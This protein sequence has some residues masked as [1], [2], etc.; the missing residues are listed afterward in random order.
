[1]T[2]VGKKK[3][4]GQVV[5]IEIFCWPGASCCWEWCGG[6]YWGAAGRR[7]HFIWPVPGPSSWEWQQCRG[8]GSPVVSTW[9]LSHD[10]FWHTFIL[11]FSN[12]HDNDWNIL[13]FISNVIL[14]FGSPK[15][16][17]GDAGCWDGKRW[18]LSSTSLTWARVVHLGFVTPFYASH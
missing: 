5:F 3:L 14:F 18:K 9:S 4:N 10:I 17:A 12:C 11:S 16:R 15:A 8:P 7:P 2:I 6:G 1:M 13:T